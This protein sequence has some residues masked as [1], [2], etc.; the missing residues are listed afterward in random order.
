MSNAK[1]PPTSPV[2]VAAAPSQVDVISNE[3]SSSSV[4][5]SEKVFVVGH[6]PLVV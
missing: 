4:D 1:V 6:C 3:E 2:I 5:V